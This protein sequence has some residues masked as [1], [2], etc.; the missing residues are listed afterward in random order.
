MKVDSE[1]KFPIEELDINE[2]KSEFS[3]YPNVK[4]E[5]YGV[6]QH[7]GSL[8]GGHYI[9]YTQNPIN[10]LWY[11]YNDSSVQQIPNDKLASEIE[12]SRSYILFY[13]RKSSENLE[14]NEETL[15]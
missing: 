7:M 10:N 4:Y 5:L 9:S 8:N 2:Y 6:V 14:D 13:K 12:N 11:E 3:F 1:V 15:E